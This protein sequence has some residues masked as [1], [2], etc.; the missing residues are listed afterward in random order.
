MAQG[1]SSPCSLYSLKL[2]NTRIPLPCIQHFTIAE[3]QQDM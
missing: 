2:Q 1:V 3:I